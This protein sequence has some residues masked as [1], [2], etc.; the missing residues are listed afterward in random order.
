MNATEQNRKLEM[1]LEI[2]KSIS[3]P[4]IQVLGGCGLA[5]T[6]YVAIESTGTI[7]L[8][9]GAFTTFASAM[10]ALLKPIKELTNVNNKIQRGIAGAQ[11]IFEVLDLPPEPDN[12]SLEIARS[13]G[14]LELKEVSFRYNPEHPYVLRDIN[15]HVDSGQVVALVGGS[16]GGKTTLVG[17]LPRLYDHYDGKILID[18]QNIRDIKLDSLRRQFAMVSQHVTL[19][20]ASIA[21]NIAYGEESIDQEKLLAAAEAAY[22]L[23]FTQKWTTGLDT[24]VGDDG[25]LLSGGQRQR[26]AIARAIYKNAPI[27]ILDEATSALDSVAEAKIQSALD[28]LMKNRTTLI[29]AHRLSTIENADNII[30]LDQGRIV[31]TGNHQEL[32]KRNGIY[33]QLHN[34]KLHHEPT[35]NA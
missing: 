10:L 7:N 1:G 19:F 29:I 9:A 30:V 27:L 2:T 28:E 4:L 18:G 34:T 15:L 23:E 3:V 6:L 21:E 16:G 20:N 22:V 31:E 25:V 17:L 14:A 32:M 35:K 33:A 24:L 26:V 13:K 12:G 11:S 8:S 5:L